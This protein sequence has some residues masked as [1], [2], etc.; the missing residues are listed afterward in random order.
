M[1]CYRRSRTSNL[2]HRRENLNHANKL[3]RA[4]V[5]L[6]GALHRNRDKA[7]ERGSRLPPSGGH[8]PY[9]EPRATQAPTGV[10]RTA[11]T[12]A[13]RKP[14]EQPHAAGTPHDPPM[15]GTDACER[16]GTRDN[17][18]SEGPNAKSEKQ[19]HAKGVGVALAPVAQAASLGEPAG[20]S[21]KSEEQ[22]M[23]RGPVQNAKN[24]P[25]QSRFQ[26]DI[27]SCAIGQ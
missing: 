1:D 21:A 24:N 18:P 3:T 16:A 6:L 5:M 9:P 10:S 15:P 12:K 25:M 7:E 19:P 27:A 8:V 4:F 23:P 11:D 14:E 20:A 2:E 22:P 26:H 13:R 17:R